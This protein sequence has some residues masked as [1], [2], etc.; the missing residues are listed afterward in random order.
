[1]IDKLLLRLAVYE[2]WSIP[3]IPPR[4]T[5]SET[6]KLA[7]RYGSAESDFFIQGVL[8]KVVEA[9]PKA[10]WDPSQMAEFEPE[11]DEEEAQEEEQQEETPAWTIRSED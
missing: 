2:L 8:G 9:S 1:M 5:V 4:V 3:G 11:K 6:I 10:E 7:R